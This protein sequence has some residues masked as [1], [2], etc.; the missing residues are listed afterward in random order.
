MHFKRL[1]WRMSFVIL[2]ILLDKQ[3]I[4]NYFSRKHFVLF[5]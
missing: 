5:I 3:E 4:A 1:G 2:S